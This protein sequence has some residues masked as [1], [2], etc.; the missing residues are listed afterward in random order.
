MQACTGLQATVAQ[1]C[2]HADKRLIPLENYGVRCM[3]MGFLMEVCLMQ[4]GRQS[5]LH[6]SPPASLGI[7]SGKNRRRTRLPSGEA[8]WS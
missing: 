1:T 3:S 6:A 4:L 2:M 8:Q 7:L 5:R